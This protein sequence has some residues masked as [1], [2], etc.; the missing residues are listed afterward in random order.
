MTYWSKVSLLKMGKTLS[1]GVLFGH[2]RQ[3]VV[4]SLERH[5]K[6]S[7]VLVALEGDSVVCFGKPASSPKKIRGIKAF[8]VRQGQAICIHTGTWHWAAFP[9]NV[10][11]CK[12]LVLF[13]IDTETSD[14]EI[15]NLPKEIGITHVSRR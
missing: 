6:T 3:A 15:G 1:T 2:E 11:E 4:R 7:E 8:Y 9:I 13:A 10:K 5:K 14:L 12:F